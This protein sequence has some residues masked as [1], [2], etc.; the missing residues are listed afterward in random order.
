LVLRGGWRNEATQPA[1]LLVTL[2]RNAL[3]SF[4][5]ERLVPLG[6]VA[7][8]TTAGGDITFALTEVGR[9]MLGTAEDFTYGEEE[10]SDI[11]VQPDFEVVFLAPSPVG[12]A[13][14]AQMAERIGDGLGA[15]FKITRRSILE[16]AAVGLDADALLDRLNRLASKAVPANVENQLSRSWFCPRPCTRVFGKRPTC[17]S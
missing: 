14:M 8:G 16:A 11:V 17:L 7:V 2:W 3:A 4:T 5:A 15:L 10:A 9:F 1:E 13:A 12:E 6:C